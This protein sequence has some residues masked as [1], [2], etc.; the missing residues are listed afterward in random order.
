M[1]KLKKKRSGWVEREKEKENEIK[2]ME[3]AGRMG[4]LTT[5]ET[6]AWRTHDLTWPPARDG[7]VFTLFDPTLTI[8]SLREEHFTKMEPSFSFG[9]GFSCLVAGEKKFFGYGS[10]H[11]HNPFVSMTIFSHFGLARGFE[12]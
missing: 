7:Q 6:R 2:K 4:N 10:A 8:V 11:A 3:K 1:T 5:Q 12:A 9:F